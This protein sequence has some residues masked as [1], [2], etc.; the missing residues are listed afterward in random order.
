MSSDHTAFD[1]IDTRSALWQ[2]RSA[3]RHL[4][5]S[6]ILSLRFAFTKEKLHRV[7]TLLKEHAERNGMDL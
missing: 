3:K 1:E 4:D 7:E 5:E 2:V 6:E